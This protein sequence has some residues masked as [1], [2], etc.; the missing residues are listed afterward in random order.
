MPDATLSGKKIILGVS[1]GIAAYKSVYLLRLL[2]QAGATVRVV[3]TPATTH[4]V[5]EL[6]FAAL[7][8]LPVFSGLWDEA[9]SEH[10][11]AGLWADLM[12]VAPA[13]AHTLAKFAHG[14][15]DNALTAVYLAA[16]C[17]I[18][19]APA[20]DLDM[21]QHPR[22]QANLACLRDDGVTV[23]P[24]GTG[25][26][27]SGLQGP[28]RLLEPEAIL[29]H[30]QAYWGP[31]PLQGKQLLLTAG[32]TQ[33]AIDPVR[34][35]SNHS[36]GK[37]GYALA[38]AAQQ[39]GATVTLVSGPTA[40]PH[41][42]GVTMVSVVS[43][44]QMYQAVMERAAAQDILIMAA[45]VADFTPIDVADQKIKKGGD[46]DMV[47]HLK[48]TPDILATVGANKLPHQRLIGFA[49]ETQDEE[50]NAREKLTRKHLD[51]IVLNS[52]RTPGAGFAHDTNQVTWLDKEGQ[53]LP[54][55]LKS[56]VEVARDILQQI[57]AMGP[58]VQE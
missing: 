56:K 8:D 15:C 23:L 44:Q 55:P 35:L 47:I 51:A 27:A 53:R 6:T 9:W 48:K 18:M 34:Y 19:V 26:L 29:Q 57:V 12:L 22:T 41:P 20:M 54:F 14:L 38:Q 58:A 45:A 43:A 7:S 24:T 16:R 31:K 25:F 40:L 49:L 52:L 2:K 30:V 36:S 21:Y 3:I 46:Q 10:V 32:P 42:T 1:G 33:E 17:P 11:E 4:F 13:T 50:A 39:M 37:M 5:G 28:G